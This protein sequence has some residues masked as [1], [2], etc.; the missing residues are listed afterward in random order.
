[1]DVVKVVGVVFLALFLVF[2][3]LGVSF[4][5]WSHD[6]VHFFAF[7]AGVLILVSVGKCASCHA[8]KK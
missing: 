5:V 7:V 6:I 3:G 2:T 1:M 4:T 8:E